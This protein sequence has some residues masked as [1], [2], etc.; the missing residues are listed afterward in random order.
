MNNNRF[1]EDPSAKVWDTMKISWPVDD[2]TKENAAKRG[3]EAPDESDIRIRFSVLPDEWLVPA[4]ASNR[5]FCDPRGITK[6]STG[7]SILRNYREVFFGPIDGN[8]WRHTPPAGW[9]RFEDIDRWWG[10]EILFDAWLDNRFDVSNVKGASPTDNLRE[11]IKKTVGPSRK[12][13]NEKIQNSWNAHK[14]AK[15]Q[16][17]AKAMAEDEERR[18]HAEAERI[19]ANTPTPEH[20]MF[21]DKDPDE[22]MEEFMERRQE[23]EDK[24]EAA[25]KK[26][27]FEAQPFSIEETSFPGSKFFDSSHF[28]GRAI[29][30]YNMG[31]VFFERIYELLESLEDSEAEG[32][33]PER[34][35]ED[36]KVLIDLM[37][38]SYARSEANFADGT[39][40]K[41]EQYID[42]FRNY[43][44]QFL[45]AYINEMDAD[46]A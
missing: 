38:I 10:C 11:T 43:W 9:S 27:I 3:G 39:L 40:L 7:F 4:L 29:L 35:V 28:S 14:E 5:E 15:R 8:V 45:S 16:A 34:A 18:T 13:A 33:D 42:D 36:M 25:K 23:Y 20:Q 30:E 32:Y 41:A 6:Q 21:R 19:A 46:S 44:G 22:S 31:H 37:I 12:T 2:E 24:E 26:K 17:T 1:P